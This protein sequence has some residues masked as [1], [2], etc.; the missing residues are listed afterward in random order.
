MLRPV[1]HANLIY[2]VVVFGKSIPRPTPSIVKSTPWGTDADGRGSGTALRSTVYQSASAGAGAKT[3][4]L[5]CAKIGGGALLAQCRRD[6]YE[7]GH[8]I[9]RAEKIYFD[10]Q[11]NESILIVTYIERISE[12]LTPRFCK[13]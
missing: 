9:S 8:N 3:I 12:G 7:S 11:E 4:G 1:E 2:T 13:A 6:V 10:K 5:N